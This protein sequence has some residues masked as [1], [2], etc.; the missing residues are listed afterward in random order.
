MVRAPKVTRAR[1]QLREAPPHILFLH[2]L[3]EQY[4][5]LAIATDTGIAECR[6]I[7]FE[8]AKFVI[9]AACVKHD[10]WIQRTQ[11]AGYDHTEG[12]TPAKG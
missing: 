3:R 10:A 9:Y 12:R 5:T 6:T 1:A 4:D 2:P 7:D 11:R 8:L